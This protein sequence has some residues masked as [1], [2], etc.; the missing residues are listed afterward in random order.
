M[1]RLVCQQGK[2]THAKGMLKN[3]LLLNKMSGSYMP[4]KYVFMCPETYLFPLH[5][6]RGY[7]EQITCPVR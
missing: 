4:Q 6:I 5:P 3:G 2:S 1:S 7:T